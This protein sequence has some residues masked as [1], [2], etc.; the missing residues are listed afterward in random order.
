[1]IKNNAEN[2]RMSLQLTQAS[3]GQVTEAGQ[4]MGTLMGAMDELIS[5]GSQLNKI[6]KNIDGIAS[7]TNLLAINATV[8]AARAGGEA[9]RSF[10]VVAEEVRFLAQKSAT[11]A[12]E[13]AAI[14][15]KNLSLIESSR[16][17]AETVGTMAKDNAEKTA[18]LEKL[19]GDISAASDEQSSGVKQI[20]VALG[21]IDE[22]MQSNAAI[23]E[24]NAASSQNLADEVARLDEAIDEAQKLI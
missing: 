12:A 17:S 18:Q 13:T 16:H 23:A 8:E 2:S 19:A 20:N 9:G 5:L 24:E 1:M 15:E 14:I 10:A 21:Q 11:S 7:Q 6:I 3:L 4:H 22:S